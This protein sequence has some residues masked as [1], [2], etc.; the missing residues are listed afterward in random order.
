MLLE[1]PASTNP[2][3]SVA[4]QKKEGLC[5]EDEEDDKDDDDLDDDQDHAG[6][7]YD[8]L[9]FDQLVYKCCWMV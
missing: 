4:G 2:F 7:D 5:D 9:G 1:P 3:I 6:H 8:N